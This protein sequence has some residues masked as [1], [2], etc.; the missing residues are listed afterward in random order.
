MK[1][2]GHWFAALACS[3]LWLGVLRCPA[4]SNVTVQVSASAAGETIPTDFLGLSFE[5]QRVLANPDGG[6]YFSPT[7]KPLIALFHT[8]GIQSLRVGGNTADRPTLPTPSKA[9]V[10][11]LFAFARAAKVKVIFTLR[12]NQGKMDEAVAMAT[13]IMQRH[14]KWVNAF[15]IGNEPN[16]FSKEFVPYFAEWQ[17]YAVAIS[18]NAPGAMFCGPGVSPG[19]EL[20][21]AYFATNLVGD[22]RIKFVTQHDYPGGDARKATNAPAERAK[23]LAPTMEEHYATFVA[24]FL[25]TVQAS[26]LAC[27]YEEAN[28]FYDGGALDVSDS[29]AS[30]LWGLDFQWWLVSHGVSGINF[31]T[32]DKVA[33]RDEN[34]PCR[35]AA[36]WTATNGYDV[37]PLGYALKLF[38]LGGRGRV[39]PIALDNPGPIN[40]T[41]YASVEGRKIYVTLINREI[42]SNAPAAQIKLV[43]SKPHQHAEILYLTAPDNNAAAKTGI[44]LGGAGIAD[45]AEWKGAWTYLPK[46]DAVG[47]FTITLPAT[48]AALIRYN[49]P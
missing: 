2:P 34:K 28:S 42:G 18:S 48:S 40:L 35:Y 30:A 11:A 9:D 7:N 49:S 25:P 22:K 31:H 41:A 43:T 21:S 3:L 27:R 38:A 20:W 19:H 47:N 45:N 46:S 17:R 37:H 1:S 13:Y 14:A 10:A 5:M 6:H 36:F 12:L 24:H 26:G 4:Q 33:A 16:V 39:L 8:L 44:L 23:I 29:F 15:A 32:G